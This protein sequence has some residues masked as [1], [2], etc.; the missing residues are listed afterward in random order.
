MVKN[1]SKSNNKKSSSKK[2]EQHI[3]QLKYQPKS[4]LQKEREGEKESKPRTLVASASTIVNSSSK[5]SNEL[6]I[7]LSLI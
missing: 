3:I 1:Y 5:S 4:K 6:K 7:L 2:P